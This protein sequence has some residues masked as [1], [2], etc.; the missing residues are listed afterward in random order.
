VYCNAENPVSAD[1]NIA[2]VAL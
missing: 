2:M 1:I